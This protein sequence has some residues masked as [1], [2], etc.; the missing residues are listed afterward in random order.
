MRR[1]L[2]DALDD[3]PDDDEDKSPVSWSVALLD[4]CEGCDDLRVVVTL[5]PSGEHGRG[6]VAHLA[7]V[8]AQR[9]RRA[10]AAAL[11]EIGVEPE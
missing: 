9:L 3:H 7:P 10:L 5:E 8:G 1:F 4:D 6:V 2:D 11:R